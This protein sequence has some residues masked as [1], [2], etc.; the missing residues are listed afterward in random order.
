MNTF[1]D[2]HAVIEQLDLRGGQ[3][4]ADFGA[5]AGAYSLAIAEKFKSSPT[6]VKIFALEVQK[7]LVERLERESTHRGLHSI[8][9]LWVDAEEH[10]GT[11]LRDHSIDWV[12]VINT[13]FQVS[14]RRGLLNEAK[15]IMKPDGKLL[16]IDWSESYRNLGPHESAV[17]SEQAAKEL[18]SEYG[19][20]AE[21]NIQAGKHHYGFIA[22]KMS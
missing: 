14:D 16:V 18:I 13:L 6:P 17:I 21:Q 20:V 22:R 8:H 15:R 10:K 1:S 4:I 5:G 19:F 11:R 9:S 7:D 2:P 3:H 12:F